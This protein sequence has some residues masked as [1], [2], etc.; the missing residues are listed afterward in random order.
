MP[1]VR[2]NQRSARTTILWVY[3][4][5]VNFLLCSTN[6]VAGNI[7]VERGRCPSCYEKWRR[8]RCQIIGYEG[9]KENKNSNP[10]NSGP[11]VD[12]DIVPTGLITVCLALKDGINFRQLV[13]QVP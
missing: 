8:T 13:P 6:D 1:Q 3:M 2:I 11:E 10:Y 9:F 7:T 12:I 4:L 5:E